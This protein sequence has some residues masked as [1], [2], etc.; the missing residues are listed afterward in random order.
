MLLQL[1]GI[2]G[3][4]GTLVS[5]IASVLSVGVPIAVMMLIGF[6]A[7]FIKGF[8]KFVDEFEFET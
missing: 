2:A 4:V 8:Q 6:T 3:I 7:V 1:S 5:V